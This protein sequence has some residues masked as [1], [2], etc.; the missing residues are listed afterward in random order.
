[1]IR[2][3]IGRAVKIKLPLDNSPDALSYALVFRQIYLGLL[4][5][6]APRRQDREA[7]APGWILDAIVDISDEPAAPLSMLSKGS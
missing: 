4:R 6:P 7:R 1:M 3:S 5:P 2:F